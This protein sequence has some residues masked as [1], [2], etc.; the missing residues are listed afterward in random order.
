VKAKIVK[1]GRSL[2]IRIPQAAAKAADLRGGDAVEVTI[3]Q[4][5]ASVS[6]E[7]S[8]DPT[9]AEL[10]ARITPENRHEEI[11]ISNFGNRDHL[12]NGCLKQLY[13]QENN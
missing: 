11:P 9:L 13:P 2:A 3:K 8:S 5:D 12:R 10:V 7:L 4:E 1:F 6:C